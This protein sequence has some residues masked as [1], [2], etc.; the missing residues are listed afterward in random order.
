VSFASDGSGVQQCT[1]YW[2][3]KA[4]PGHR[5]IIQA[6]TS[7]A[8]DL[9]DGTVRTYASFYDGGAAQPPAGTSVPVSASAQAAYTDTVRFAA[10]ANAKSL[11]SPTALLRLVVSGR[12]SGLPGHY[13]SDTLFSVDAM[14]GPFFSQTTEVHFTWNGHGPAAETAGYFHPMPPSLDP[15]RLIAVVQ[16]TL[17]LAQGAQYSLGVSQFTEVDANLTTGALAEADFSH[18]SRLTVELPDGWSFS[19]DSGVLLS[20]V[21]EPSPAAA[22]TAGFAW[23]AY[24]RRK[25][26]RQ[27]T[28]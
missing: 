10:M 15:A 18:T 20:A 22:L 9:R 25:T 5:S 4:D 12:F 16:L 1:V 21:P 28:A 19:S 8:A 23:L 13:D 6:Q 17:P 14:N 26:W 11:P 27:V 24:V 7:A 2:Y 3:G